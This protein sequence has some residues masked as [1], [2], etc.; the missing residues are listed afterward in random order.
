MSTFNFSYHI[1]LL[2]KSSSAV[3]NKQNPDELSC[4]L[5]DLQHFIEANY[6]NIEN[7]TAVSLSSE[8]LEELSIGGHLPYPFLKEP[9]SFVS[10]KQAIKTL[11]AENKC[12]LQNLKNNDSKQLIIVYWYCRIICIHLSFF[13]Q[14][15]LMNYNE[16]LELLQS[17]FKGDEELMSILLQE[18][19]DSRIKAK[20][21][22]LYYLESCK[23]S[24]LLQNEHLYAANCLNRY[25]ALSKMNYVL[26][27]CQTQRTKYQTK[28]HNNLIILAESDSE[29]LL[30]EDQLFHKDQN[31]LVENLKLN[32]DVLLN[33]PVYSKLET[34]DAV[35]EQSVLP[36][37]NNKFLKTVS[38]SAEIP[39]T[40]A[41]LDFNNQ[42][43]LTFFDEIQFLLRLEAI[44]ISSPAK[45]PLVEQELM[46]IID[47]LT[48]NI[49]N[50]NSMIFT[51]TLWERSL[52]ETSKAK[53]IERA[54][55]QM[56]Q[57]INDL[58]DS[59]FQFDS[60]FF[61]LLP[62]RPT[63]ILQSQLAE[64]YMEL[65]VVKSAMEIYK[66]LHMV[67]ELALCHCAVGEENEGLLLLEA[68]LAE[69]PNEYRSMSIIGDIKQDP[70]Y[71]KEAWA[72]GKYLN[73]KISLAKYTYYKLKNPQ[74]SMA[75]FEE[76]N[77]QRQ[78]FDNIYLY[79]CI[80]LQTEQWQKA[81][82][83]FQ[84]CVQMDETNLKCWS[85]LGAALVE[86]A[87]YE[88]AYSAFSKA[89]SLTTGSST[90]S[91]NSSQIIQNL[92]IISLRL[93]KWNQV[94]NCYTKL[95]E[96]QNLIDMEV[97][98]ELF[99][100]LTNE[101]NTN[102]YQN[103]LIE[104]FEKVLPAKI[105]SIQSPEVT[106]VYKLLSRYELLQKRPW[107]S[108]N[109]TEISFR[110]VLNNV[111]L[112]TDKTTFLKALD[113]LNDLLSSY[114]N[115]GPMDGRIEG[116]CVCKNWKYKCK[117]TIKL[118]MGKCDKYWSGEDEWEELLELRNSY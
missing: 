75:H 33:R 101:S 23:V 44:K 114:E 68:R 15:V 103:K 32:H 84:T 83:A 80:A 10:L 4:I 1:S 25:S 62:L 29:Q 118:V 74:E 30:L 64:K 81:K 109:Y 58:Q 52:I 55:L 28:F 57:L 77:I 17:F 12:D 79:G 37:Y 105:S 34:P 117:M 73:A 91:K 93:K 95:I 19:D 78:S 98:Q 16:E 38:T 45:D 42:P 41:A 9:E 107:N 70:K 21:Q 56:E 85:N 99:E 43:K 50:C 90:I 39:Q 108:L 20:I 31:S 49:D 104:F 100:Q 53:T 102:G 60:Q 40:L 86:V 96:S 116:A 97:I 24:I 11:I 54:L 88:Q 2:L 13:N 63:W 14:N 3:E 6:T 36:E 89:V 48:S 26:T 61:F 7:K 115:L 27:G 51:C 92:M 72:K 35:E 113:E 59:N 66:R 106:D 82:Q 110:H 8:M 47:R 94:L 67:N 87:M 65:G 71:W 76:C 5:Q 112:T 18:L 111:A 69:L 22:Q 46:A